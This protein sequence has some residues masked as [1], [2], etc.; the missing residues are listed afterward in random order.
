MW[1]MR[2]LASPSHDVVKSFLFALDLLGA[3]N[4]LRQDIRCTPSAVAVG[5]PIDIIVKKPG[6]VRLSIPVVSRRFS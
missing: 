2:I 1:E 3:Q 4:V 6:A 5:I